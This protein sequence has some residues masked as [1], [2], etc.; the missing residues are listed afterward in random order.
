MICIR[1]RK[2]VCSRQRVCAKTNKV[3]VREEQL[4]A[5]ITDKQV[6]PNLDAIRPK[7]EGTVGLRSKREE[8][9]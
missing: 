5:S 3:P 4:F 6:P 8:S 7:L 2:S 9:L 1:V